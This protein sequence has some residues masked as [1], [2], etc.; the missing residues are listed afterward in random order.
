MRWM[1]GACG[2][3]DHVPLWRTLQFGLRGT[4]RCPAQHVARALGYAPAISGS[5][6]YFVAD[7]AAVRKWQRA[8]GCRRPARSSPGSSSSH[9]SR[10]G[11]PAYTSNSAHRRR[12]A[13]PRTNSFVGAKANGS[14]ARRRCAEFDVYARQPEREGCEERAARARRA[15]RRQPVGSLPFPHC[16]FGLRTSTAG[17]AD[18]RCI[19]KRRER[20]VELGNVGSRSR[21]AV[22]ATV[23]VDP[24]DRHAPAIHL[25]QR[26][27]AR[28]TA[29]GAGKP[30]VGLRIRRQLAL[31]PTRSQWFRSTDECP[32]VSA[33][34]RRRR[35]GRR[36][37]RI[38]CGCRRASRRTAGQPATSGS[39]QHC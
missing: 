39:S 2:P 20:R 12:P 28:I 23:D 18:R 35:Y 10:S 25:I 9:P 13:G 11:L 7:Q 14:P 1:A 38:V 34:H 19:A 26:L 32:Q 5:Q 15:G 22:S 29:P 8:T 24:E 16:C 4:R 17:T 37:R 33:Y 21:T 27:S 31:S 6:L 3:P 30:G 36:S